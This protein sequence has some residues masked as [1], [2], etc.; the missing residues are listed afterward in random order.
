MYALELIV[1]FYE[2]FHLFIMQSNNAYE[3]MAIHT[4]ERSGK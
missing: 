4:L 3:V 1:K 2:I